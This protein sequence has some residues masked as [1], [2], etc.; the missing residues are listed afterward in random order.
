[1]KSQNRNKLTVLGNKLLV[2]K[3]EGQ[4]EAIGM[5]FG[6]GMYALLGLLG[7][8]GGKEPACQSRRLKRFGFDPGV[9]QIPWRRIQYSC[10]PLQ[11][12]CLK[13]PMDRGAWWATV[14]GVVVG[15]SWK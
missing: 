8:A 15:H 5:E 7:G 10:S 3:G 12:S 6:I 2:A 9:R 1:M 11:Y 13:N 4:R 14:H